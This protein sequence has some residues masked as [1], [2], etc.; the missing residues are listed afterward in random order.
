MWAAFFNFAAAF[1]FGTGVARP[2]ARA[3]VDIMIVTLAVICAGL[4]GAIVVESDD[5]VFRAAD[6]LV[7]RAFRRLCGRR[8]GQGRAWPPSSAPMHGWT[9]TLVFIVVSPLIG[10]AV[11]YC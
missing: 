4:V 11:G 9:K 1:V 8:D 2:S 5:V 6:E 10:L 7:A 3:L